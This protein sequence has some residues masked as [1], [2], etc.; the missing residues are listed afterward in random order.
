MKQFAVIMLTLALLVGCASSDGRFFLLDPMEESADRI[1][2]KVPLGSRVAIASFDAGRTRLADYLVDELTEMLQRRSVD[3]A[4]WQ[5]MEYAYREL[6][7]HMSDISDETAQT[8]GKFLGADKVI[9]GSFTEANGKFYYKTAIVDTAQAVRTELTQ[10]EIRSSRAMQRSVE[11]VTQQAAAPVP[12]EEVR[13]DNAGTFLDRGILYARRADY[14]RAKADFSE[15][16]QLNPS[17]AAAYINRGLVHYHER[18]YREALADFTQT[19]A[20]DPGY[21][22]AY[23]SRG[24]AYRDMENFD[25]AITDYNYAIALSPR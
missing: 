22:A 7:L 14:E 10:F 11:A 5:N 19:I 12:N 23:N 16:V 6:N 21:A 13:S 8:I 4:S 9:I 20:L 2:E 1:T 18:S 25:A 24:N 3:V 17:L 15:A